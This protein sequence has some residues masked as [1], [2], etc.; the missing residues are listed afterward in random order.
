MSL[1]R[2]CEWLAAT[3]GS[4]AIHN[5][6]YVYQIVSTVHVVTLA[7]FVGTASMLD[8]RLL[9]VTMQRVPVSDVA[10]RLRPWTVGGFILM[11]VSG[12]LLF[13]ANPVPRYQNL[14]FR[15]KMLMLVLAGVNAWVFQ[16]TS[17]RT[18]A[19]WDRDPVPPR[20]ARMAGGLALMLWAGMI[21][22]GRMIAYDWFDCSRQPQRA[23]VNLL[24]GCVTGSR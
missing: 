17:Y 22:S 15:S 14:F 24:E 3:P 18:A 20:R 5:S 13:Y 12:A 1:L 8:L 7:L 2:V 21:M 10:S 11:L 6:L 23:I 9:G 4:I 16:R 19:E